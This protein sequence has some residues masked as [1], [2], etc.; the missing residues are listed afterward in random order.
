M[1]DHERTGQD[2]GTDGCSDCV[3]GDRGDYSRKHSQVNGLIAIVGLILGGAGLGA[4]LIKLFGN[5]QREAGQLEERTREQQ[6]ANA[7]I[8]RAD[9]V[10]AEHRDPD[11]TAARLRRH[12]F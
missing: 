3:S 5:S 11:D 9:D 8:H 12:D 4:L 6:E 10:L 1:G 7:A 2:G